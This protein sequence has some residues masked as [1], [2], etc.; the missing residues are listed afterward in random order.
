ML[1]LLSASE[2]GPKK[3]CNNILCSKCDHS[4]LRF[5]G[6]RWN[7]LCDY[8]FFRNN[9]PSKEKLTANLVKSVDDAAFCCQCSWITINVKK[10]LFVSS[11]DQKLRWCCL[12]H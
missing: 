4:V 3:S 2:N 5:Q 8:L 6:M 10:D 7:E 12:G 9:V 11:M 1:V